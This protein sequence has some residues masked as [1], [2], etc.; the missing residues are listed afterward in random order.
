VENLRG[1][2]ET[3]AENVIEHVKAAGTILGSDVEE[4]FEQVKEKFSGRSGK[5]RE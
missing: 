5:G 1:K 2:A 3:E 4:V